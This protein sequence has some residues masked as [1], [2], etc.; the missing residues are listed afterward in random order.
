MPFDGTY[1]RY[2]YG[3]HFGSVDVVM[4]RFRTVTGANGQKQLMAD[5]IDIKNKSE[6]VASLSL[7]AMAK[8]LKVHGFK[9]RHGSN[10]IWQ[11]DAT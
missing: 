6:S 4:L 9:W 1:P 7:Q 3:D 10:G 8:W 5:A 11:R 2:P